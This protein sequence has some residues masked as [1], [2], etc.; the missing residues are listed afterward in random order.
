M[1]NTNK[2]GNLKIEYGPYDTLI[3]KFDIL[4]ASVR[5]VCSVLREVGGGSLPE[6][7]TAGAALAISE[8]SDSLE[9]YMQSKGDE[10]YF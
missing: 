5:G 10:L 6:S 4:Q 9:A 3:Q 2:Q 7:I 8:F 1:E